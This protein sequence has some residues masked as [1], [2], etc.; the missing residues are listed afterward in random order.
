MP[1]AM[2]RPA[3]SAG[4]V[5][6]ATS[7]L[8]DFRTAMDADLNTADALAALF[9]LVGQGNAALD[10]AGSV[11][12]KERDAV[13]D[14]LA[15]MDRVLGLLEVA[16]TSRALDADTVAWVDRMVVERQSARKAKDFARGDEI[17]KE[18]SAKGIVLEDSA[19]GTRW[20]VVRRVEESGTRG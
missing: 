15:S 20:K 16:R 10:R 9:V 2:S 17:R 7:A 8:A 14:A 1:A 5:E 6:L 18:L 3:P 13:R 12:P 19:Q 11:P 4:L